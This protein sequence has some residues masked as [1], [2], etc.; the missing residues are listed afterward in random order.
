MTDTIKYYLCVG[1]R[2]SAHNESYAEI[3][4]FAMQHCKYNK[5]SAEIMGALYRDGIMVRAQ[6][7][8]AYVGYDLF[9][10]AYCELTDFGASLPDTH[11]TGS[12]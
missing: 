5:T 3:K 7:L 2:A 11:E 8:I 9:G 12:K 6:I 4:K 1:C 10:N